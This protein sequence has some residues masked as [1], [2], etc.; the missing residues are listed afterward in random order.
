[1]T[2]QWALLFFILDIIAAVLGFSSSGEAW[3][4][5]LSRI[6]FFVFLICFVVSLVWG[7]LVPPKKDR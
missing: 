2:L 5:G 4:F 1:M 3:E 7:L 6:L